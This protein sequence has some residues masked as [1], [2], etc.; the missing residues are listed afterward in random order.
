MQF[1]TQAIAVI[2]IGLTLLENQAYNL[3]IQLPADSTTNSKSW[4]HTD[5]HFIVKSA[6]DK[7][8]L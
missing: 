3:C 7:M 1:T 2:G 8:L 5:H 4:V 6:P